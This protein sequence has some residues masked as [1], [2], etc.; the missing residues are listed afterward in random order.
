[1]R[2]NAQ[3]EQ[4]GLVMM[5][6]I[7]QFQNINEIYGYHMGNR[8]LRA[9]AEQLR[10]FMRERGE[11][12]R[13]DGAKFALCFT[14][15]SP[16]QAKQDYRAIQQLAHHLTVEDGKYIP[17]SIS[18][19]A[20][21]LED[22]SA[23][24]YVIRSC[25]SYAQEASKKEQHSELVFFNSE[26]KRSSMRLLS[27]L[28]A[29]R[30]SVFDHCDGF[31]L[32]YQPLVRP[33][34]GEIIGMEALVRWQKEP[35]GLVSPNEFIPWL[36]KDDCFFELGNWIL[37]RAM[38]DAK[39][40]VAQHPQFVVNVNVAYTQLDH[41]EFRESLLRILY[42]TGFPPQNLCIELTERCRA[43]DSKRLKDLLDFMA[44]HGIRVALDD[45]GTGT[46]ALD[47][48]RALPINTIKLDRSFISD[49]QSNR[50]TEVLVG[51][52]VESANTLG[53]GVCIEGIENERM[54]DFVQRYNV[55]SLQGYY[56]SRP[57]PFEEFKKL[58][59]AQTT[60]AASSTG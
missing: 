2:Q 27:I 18:G 13:L 48:L 9:F 51:F 29:V 33:S 5:I 24:E 28:E 35:F 31:E 26:K 49:I 16:E 58:M 19:G 30:E 22:A 25:L 38:L 46:A 44:D 34:N 7:N 36:E 57:V 47:L 8:V 53:M 42:E 52:V 50:A 41:S 39:T 56:Y 3:S 32:Y 54:R 6:A 37:R 17:L 21:V 60:P 15:N 40:I 1:M 14:D 12:Y 23:S 45:F 10:I 55:S 4:I 11:V 59:A 43:L 20:M